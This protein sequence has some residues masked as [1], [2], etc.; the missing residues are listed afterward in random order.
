MI[1]ELVP[2]FG[3]L[4]CVFRIRSVVD[5]SISCTLEHSG[6]LICKY[7]RSSLSTGANLKRLELLELFKL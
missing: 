5:T 4:F 2:V 1:F 3:S 7:F 6:L